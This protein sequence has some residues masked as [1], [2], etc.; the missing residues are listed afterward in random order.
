MK[1]F[2]LL[3]LFGINTLCFAAYDD[4]FLNRTL[5]IDY[6]HSGNAKEEYFALDEL[7]QEPTWDR[8]RE[9]L[10]NPFDFGKYKFLA[11]DSVTGELIYQTSYSTLFGEWQTTAE[12]GLKS[13]AFQETVI[14]PFPKSIIRVEFYSRNSKNDW[15]KKWSFYIKPNDI[16]ISKEIAFQCK[17]RQLQFVG[18]PAHKLD[19]VFLA[20][21]YTKNQMNKFRGDARRFMNYILDC[22]PFK[23][24]K[25]A[26]NFWT[27]ESHSEE[28]GTDIPGISVWKQTILNSHFYT[29]YSDRYLTTFDHKTMR[30]LASNAPYDH[31][32]VLVNSDKYGGGGFY[33]FYSITSTD[34]ALSNFVMVHELGHDLAGL[35]DEY[36]T[37]EVAMQNFY[38]KDTEPWE[39]NLTTMV[40][41]NLKWKDLVKPSTPVPT[42][43]GPKYD[44]EVGV[45]EGGGYAEKGVYRP[46]MDCTMKSTVYNNFC[47]VCKRA[48]SKMIDYYSK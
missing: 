38:P 33:N 6:I 37:G 48:I 13:K 44:R 18:E 26:I 36:Y 35:G 4:L 40:Q 17:T 3:A 28:S 14:M 45:F 27:V 9:N 41:F 1:A 19:L 23:N 7:I 20:E 11:Y 10:I 24:Y 25:E 47:P 46:K 22:E 42:P 2:L 12:A 39:P 32:I 5:R 43:P 16:L 29:F 8:N 31:I 30:H 34:D 15:V 21:G